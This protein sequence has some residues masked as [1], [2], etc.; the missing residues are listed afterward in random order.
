MGKFTTILKD[1]KNIGEQLENDFEYKQKAI[2]TELYYESGKGYYVTARALV[3]NT[4]KERGYKS[5]TSCLFRDGYQ[6]ILASAKRKSKA[7]EEEATKYYNEN[8][9]RLAI[10][11]EASKPE[12]SIY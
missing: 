6:K 2:A 7:G 1:Y 10:I 11:C 8:K 9:D 4:N 5:E 3:V 12:F